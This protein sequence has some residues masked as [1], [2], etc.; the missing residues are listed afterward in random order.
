M[1][2]EQKLVIIDT[3]SLLFRA[4][5]AIPPLTIKDGTVV[6]AAFGF[7]SILMKLIKDLKPDYILAAFDLA[8]PTFRHIEY[9]EYKGQREKQPDAFYHQIELVENILDAFKIPRLSK[10]GFEA[11][12]IIGSI[13]RIS[14]RDHP[15]IK[16]I[17]VTGDL[18]S[19]QLVTERTN[20]Y[21]MKRGISDTILYDVA[22]VKKA[23]GSII[24]GVG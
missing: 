19:L 17:I 9:K 7:T 18:D 10:A 5:H 15:E 24:P 3:F 4:W 13:V 6:N 23:T 8:E 21:T 22:A 1:A 11:D 2:K 14:E 16:N 20:V 12:D